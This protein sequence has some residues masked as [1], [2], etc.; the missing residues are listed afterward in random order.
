MFRDG[1][2]HGEG[3]LIRMLSSFHPKCAVIKSGGDVAFK[4]ETTE[5]DAAF[6]CEGTGGQSD[7]IQKD[8]K[9]IRPNSKCGRLTKDRQKDPMN[10]WTNGVLPFTSQLSPF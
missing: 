5:C 1:G 6:M 7:M 3:C 10:E 2:S 9:M 4:C 8:L